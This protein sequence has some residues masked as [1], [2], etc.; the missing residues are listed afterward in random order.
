MDARVYVDTCGETRRVMIADRDAAPIPPET[1]CTRQEVTGIFL[2]RK[3]SSVV[4]N[5][6]DPI[7]TVL[8]VQGSYDL[9]PRGPRRQAPRGLVVFG[10]GGPGRTTPTRWSSAAAA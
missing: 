10:G 9:R 1:D 4:V 2:V 6:G 5:V 3:V 7:A 8:L